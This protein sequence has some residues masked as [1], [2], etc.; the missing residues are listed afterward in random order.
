MLEVGYADGGKAHDGDKGVGESEEG[1]FHFSILFV[2]VSP[3]GRFP[4]CPPSPERI[5]GCPKMRRFGRK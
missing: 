2:G 5:T 1:A 3:E 4:V